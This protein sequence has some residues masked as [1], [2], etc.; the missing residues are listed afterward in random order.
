MDKFTLEEVRLIRVYELPD[1]AALISD[2]KMSL[3]HVAEREVNILMR[4]V[5]NKLETTSDEEYAEMGFDSEQIFEYRE[6]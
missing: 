2:L 3:P 6:V 4:T 5:I 1:R